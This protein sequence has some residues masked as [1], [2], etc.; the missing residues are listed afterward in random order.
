MQTGKT[1]LLT[2]ASGFIGARC[3]PQLN[4]AGYEVHGTATRTMVPSPTGRIVWHL[5]DLLDAAECARIIEKIRPT[6]LLHLAWIATPGTF[7]T[8][9]A[10]LRW[11]AGGVALI[12]AF[13]RG[14][15]RRAV[16][17]G[18][19]AEYA[20]G[21][22]DVSELVT[23]LRP[24]T[25]YGRCKLAMGL[26][27]GAAAS[28]F[29]GSAAWA[30]LFFP[31]GPGEPAQRIIPSVI[32]GLLRHEP[33]EC[34]HGRQV[35]DFVFVDDVAEALV[36]LL[37]SGAEG[38]FNVGSGEGM[39]LRDVVAVITE[40]LGQ[41]DL[42]RFGIRHSPPGDPDRVVAD[43]GRINR[44]IGWRPHVGIEEGIARSIAALRQPAR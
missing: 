8:S 39:A 6:H 16:G 5:C 17:A 22:D 12:E 21:D 37:D 23:P 4:E 36:A 44:E 7:W 41:S 20:W 29:R 42:V 10:N 33:V 1:V 30:R 14:G 27:F 28:A 35:R 19:C 32:Q 25:A 40:K 3:V 43:I 18:S 15:G 9:P 26:A 38:P 2:G 24:E 13:F 11:L 31:Y 34:T